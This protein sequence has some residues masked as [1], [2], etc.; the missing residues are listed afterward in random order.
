MGNRNLFDTETRWYRLSPMQSGMLIDTLRHTQQDAG[1]GQNIEQLHMVLTK[2]IDRSAFAKA[3]TFVVQRHAILSTSFRWEALDM[4]MQ[5]SNPDM[6]VPVEVLELGSVDPALRAQGIHRFL[7]DDRRRGFD[8]KQPPLM[9]V[10]M[11]PG[12]A[13][14]TDVIWTFHHILLD[15]RSLAL[16]LQ[17]VFRAYSKYVRGEQ[18]SFGRPPQPYSNF[19][20]WLQ[21]QDARPSLIFFNDLLRGKAMPT[22]L[23]C[24]EPVQRMFAR[25]G[26]GK[27]VL[28][29]PKAIG[30]LARTLAERT[31]TTLATV[32]NAAWALVL[33]RYTSDEDVLFGTTRACR[34][35]ALNGGAQEMPGLFVNTLPM[36]VRTHSERTI[37]D[38]IWDLRAQSVALRA[39]EHTSLTDVQGQS[40]I[41][42]GT[43][44]FESL[45]MF[46]HENLNESLRGRLSSEWQ[47]CQFTLIE[48]PAVPLCV[49]VFGSA[50]I[51]IRIIFDR[52]RFADAAIDRLANS[53]SRGLEQLGQDPS[54]TLADVDV[55]PER[56]RTRIL[57]EW[58]HTRRE[59]PDALSI[60]ELFESR[61]D[62]QPDAVAIEVGGHGI[63][64]LE[65]EQRSNRLAHLLRERGARPGTF[66]GICLARS[67]ELVVAL[68]A[69]AKAAAAYV[70]LDPEYPRERLAFMVADSK[71]TLIIT[72]Q[73]YS[74]LFAA[75]LSLVYAA[76]AEC[77]AR[78]PTS[79]PSRVGASSDVCYVIYTSGSTGKPKGVV[80]SHRA[81]VNTFD[82]VNRTLEVGPGDRLLL[83]TSPCFDLSVYDT[84]GV[85]GAG[86]TVVIAGTTLLR[87]P[88]RL[89][90]TI[91]ELG[92]TIWDS[93]PA[94]LQQL[95]AYFPRAAPKSKLRRVMLSG[96]WIPMSLPEAVKAAFPGV[97]VTSL[98]GATEAAIWSNWF[99]IGPIDPRWTSIPYGKPIQNVR[100]HV[101]DQRLEP[102]PVGVP[103]DLYI[104]GTC[105]AECYLNQ[106]ELT[107]ERFISRSIQARND[108]T[109]V[110]Y[111]RSRTLL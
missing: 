105:L 3:W 17:E 60:H 64:Y 11:V 55:L 74:S 26:H 2:A 9:R 27:Q 80:L 68:L 39:H 71:A 88:E 30:D 48:Q 52:K 28:V 65:L 34:R 59:Y 10:T 63:S 32:V 29:I 12:T 33:S 96:D 107:A 22:P 97:K 62:T 83:V 40:Q 43:A 85:L 67:V 61:V 49:T 111:R 69:V 7:R 100:Y 101:L 81:V 92:I 94:A 76:D 54:R 5:S 104:G 23:P 42:R 18:P 77:I 84:F 78:Q 38:L 1:A 6:S 102:V 4:P 19:I 31:R 36:R 41:P 21:S 14:L 51:E 25:D 20:H 90:R 86:A 75:D 46:E 57:N 45:I 8:L 89:A 95:V 110:R 44:L 37:G 93:A 82:W 109:P 66:V 47:T 15:G 35:S 72:D 13:C 106:P 91:V 99:E 73:Q 50:A 24:A 79:R 87:D 53:L 103:G 108:R 70:P 16:V 58:N 98:G 56:E